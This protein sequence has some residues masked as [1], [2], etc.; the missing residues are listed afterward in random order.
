M[1]IVS[2]LLVTQRGHGVNPHGAPRGNVAGQQR[3]KQHQNSRSQKSDGVGGR[4]AVELA[5]KQASDGEGG[6]EAEGEADEGEL[7]A[8]FQ[9]EPENIPRQGAKRHANADF[10]GAS[11][12]EERQDAVDADGAE[13]ESESR[14]GNKEDGSG[15]GGGDGF[16]D[17]GVHRLD[18]T[19]RNIGAQTENGAPKCILYLGFL[20]AGLNDEAHVR[21]HTTTFESSLFVVR[22]IDGAVDPVRNTALKIVSTNIGDNANDRAPFL[23]AAEADVGA[24]TVLAG[25]EAVGGGGAD[26]NDGRIARSVSGGEGA[27]GQDRNVHDV[28][29]IRSD[30]IHPEKRRIVSGSGDLIFDFEGALGD[31][32]AERKGVDEGSGSDTGSGVKAVDECV[33]KGDATPGITAKRLIG[34]HAG[35]EQTTGAKAG[36]NVRKGPEAA[37]Q[38][39]GGNNEEDCERDFGDSERAAE[40]MGNR[41]GRTAS[42]RIEAAGQSRMG[43]LQS[44]SQTEEK[45]GE[46]GECAGED[47]YTP[48]DVGVGETGRVWRESELEKLQALGGEEQPD[49]TA[50]KCEQN[51]FG[52]ELADDAC[53]VRTHG[54][55]KGDFFFTRASAGESEIRDIDAGNE[56]DEPNSVEEKNQARA[57]VGNHIVF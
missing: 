27:T 26:D 22:K 4:D 53:A 15:R 42:D 31:A 38:K 47:E 14:K 19:D 52:E 6:S 48:I 49:K 43:R 23:V 8:F 29:V 35:G 30:D 56:K 9:D 11:G 44:G 37:D 1:S 40:T 41:G 36:I 12:D 28:E 34:S 21:G 45:A 18:F 25:P 24:D 33:V 5:G 55:T 2:S 3:D 13:H 10:A 51:A 46:D 7:R 50:E 32:S 17:D 20:Q 54:E 16:R 39:P 57:H